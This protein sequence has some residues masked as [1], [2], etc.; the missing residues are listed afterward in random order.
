[1]AQVAGSAIQ[2]PPASFPFREEIESSF[3]RPIPALAHFDREAAE[4]CDLLDANAFTSAGHVAF[5]TSQP[6][7]Q[8]AAHEAAH[9]VQQRDGRASFEGLGRSGDIHE[10]HADQVAAAVVAGRPAAH[11]LGYAMLRGSGGPQPAVQL[12]KKKDDTSFVGGEE[13]SALQGPDDTEWVHPGEGGYARIMQAAT[14]QFAGEFKE[15]TDTVRM[16]PV[17]PKLGKIDR[18]VAIA[19]HERD[20]YKKQDSGF[21]PGSI[22]RLWKDRVKYADDKATQY[23]EDKRQEQANFRSYNSFISLGNSLIEQIARIEA[24]KYMMGIKD[25]AAM[26]AA[27]TERM[28][29]ARK[30]A[31]RAQKA[32]DKNKK[33][34][35][36]EVEA[37]AATTSVD[38]AA[39]KLRG[40]ARDLDSSYLAFQEAVSL[41]Q[42]AAAIKESGADGQKRLDEINEIKTFLKNVG[43]TADFAQ[44]LVKKAPEQIANWVEKP[45][46]ML[47]SAEK[48]IELI[49]DFIYWEEVNKLTTMLDTLNGMIEKKK[50]VKEFAKVSSVSKAYRSALL[51]FAEAAVEMQRALHERRAQYRQLGTKLDRF[52]QD[53]PAL[54]KEGL[55]PAAGGDRYAT[56]MA[57][58]VELRQAVA[59]ARFVK[60]GMPPLEGGPAADVGSKAPA[61]ATWASGVIQHRES[62]ASYHPNPTPFDMPEDEKQALE[63][64]WSFLDLSDR[65]SKETISRFGPLDQ[66]AG[67][68]MAALGGMKGV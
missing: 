10:R 27:L 40:S 46:S 2:G 31:G 30:V 66:S 43:K 3:G 25:D 53:D 35:T 17:A 16:K 32:Y 24:Q 59:L 20:W 8:L 52:A 67:E 55:A 50:L 61:W 5:G 42:E 48:G 6:S 56:S 51:K 23:T 49:T 58:V 13:G 60:D 33:E 21:A 36:E 39:Q 18:A 34:G 11:L 14:G 54:R 22:R 9:A 45:T 47:P 62:Y 4:A 44:G 12:E 37:P 65:A 41:E 26:T 28:E 68:L 29:D 38:G 57:L 64:A 19:I 7:L 15:L 1:V 63:Q